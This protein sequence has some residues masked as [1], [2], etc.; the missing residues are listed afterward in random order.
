MVALFRGWWQGGGEGTR[1]GARQEKMGGVAPAHRSEK[2]DALNG[3]S[4]L[5]LFPL[6]EMPFTETVSVLA[7]VSQEFGMSNLAFIFVVLKTPIVEKSWVRAKHTF[8]V[9]L[10]LIMRVGQLVA[11]CASSP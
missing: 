8:P 3:Q 1:R 10:F 6:E 11:P 4:M 9:A 7:P 5:T 2:S